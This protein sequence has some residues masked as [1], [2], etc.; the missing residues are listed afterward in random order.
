VVTGKR[1]DSLIK[2]FLSN[3]YMTGRELYIVLLFGITYLSGLFYNAI[4]FI[5]SVLF[6]G[7]KSRAGD[8]LTTFCGEYFI[9]Y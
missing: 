6:W 7:A 5:L 3:Q 8:V 9:L 1:K 2:E 4:K